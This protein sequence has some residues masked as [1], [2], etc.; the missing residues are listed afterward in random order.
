MITLEPQTFAV[1]L[2]IVGLV[3]VI[4]GLWLGRKMQ[5]PADPGEL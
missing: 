5:E 3:G 1:S 4:V 2:L